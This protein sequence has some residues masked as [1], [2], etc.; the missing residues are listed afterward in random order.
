MHTHPFLGLN[1]H[2]VLQ[3]GMAFSVESGLCVPDVA[4]FRHSDTVV[5]TDTDQE[6]LSLYPRDLT[7]LVV[8][9]G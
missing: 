4:G 6:R 9:A 3:P 1:D 2:T 7:A 8:T 5:I